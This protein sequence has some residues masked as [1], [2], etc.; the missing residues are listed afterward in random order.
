M[1][2]ELIMYESAFQF[3]KFCV[4][5]DGLGLH[6]FDGKCFLAGLGVCSHCRGPKA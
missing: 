2:C 3:T 5:R 1:I 4:S 6:C